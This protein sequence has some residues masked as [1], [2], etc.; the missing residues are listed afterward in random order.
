[1]FLKTCKFEITRDKL[2]KVPILIK[3]DIKNLN[4]VAFAFNIILL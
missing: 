4:F 3:N 1:M 2:V